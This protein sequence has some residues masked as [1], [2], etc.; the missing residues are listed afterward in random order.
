MIFSFVA[1]SSEVSGSE[2]SGGITLGNPSSD[3]APQESAV[4]N[5]ST[6]ETQIYIQTHDGHMI[7]FQLNES[8]AAKAF[9]AQLPLNIRVEDY[10]GSEKIFYPPEKLDIVDA[11]TAKGPVGTLAYYE[12]WGNVAIFYKECD[13]ASGLYGLGEAVAG[14]E[15]LADLSGEIHITTLP[16][17]NESQISDTQLSEDVGTPN[18]SSLIAPLPETTVSSA[19]QTVITIDKIAGNKTTVPMPTPKATLS[20]ISEATP[21]PAMES[22][23]ETDN[24]MYQIEIVVGD[25]NFP[26]VL[27]KNKTTDALM[28]RLPMTLDMNDMNENE[29][30]YYFS[31]SLPTNS[32]RPSEIRAGDLMLYGSDCLVLFYESFSSSYS[33]TALGHVEN[34]VGL[35]SALGSGNLQ[36]SFNAE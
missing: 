1:C 16:E 19:V 5:E 8:L 4:S 7:T 13:G 12:P 2:P 28:A 36:V 9:Y 24:S 31:N 18:G 32:E 23:T 35:A 20:P 14:A 6:T 25:Q 26:T 29:K 17:A 27:Y 33:Y 30:Y 22:E 11:P 34:A 21:P 10:A 15:L 3:T